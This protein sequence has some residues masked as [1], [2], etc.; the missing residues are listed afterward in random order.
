M[1]LPTELKKLEAL[2]QRYGVSAQVKFCGRLSNQELKNKLARSDVFVMLSNQTKTGDVEGFG[3]AILEANA[4][5]IPAIGATG[6][7]IE[8]AIL[9]G[10]SGFLIEKSDVNGFEKALE[11]MLRNKEEFK[12]NALQWAHEHDWKLVVKQ[13]QKIIETCT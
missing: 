3:I 5:G 1:G 6:A 8:D 9:Q 7:G 12:Q 10:K 4:L 13:Y 11:T 2:V